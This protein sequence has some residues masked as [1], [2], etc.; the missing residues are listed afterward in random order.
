MKIGIDLDNTINESS[1]SISFFSLLTNSFKGKCK[2]F[3]I[4]NRDEDDRKATEEELAELK[5]YYDYLIITDKKAEYILKENI[6][7]Y[8]DDTDEY[9]IELPESVIVLKIREPGNFN[10]TKGSNKW[11]YSSRTGIN[12]DDK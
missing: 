4:T 7:V 8:I 9:F 1:N 3:I 2:I 6:S 12:I 10:F 11:F 5:I